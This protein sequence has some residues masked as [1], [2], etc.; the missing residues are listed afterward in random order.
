MTG[1]VFAT[2]S[3]YIEIGKIIHRVKGDVSSPNQIA[4]KPNR[5]L[6]RSEAKL[7]LEN[8]GLSVN[9]RNRKMLAHETQLTQ[10]TSSDEP[11]VDGRGTVKHY[12]QVQHGKIYWADLLQFANLVL[13]NVDIPQF[14]RLE[15][16]KTKLTY[17]PMSKPSQY[18]LEAEKRLES[19]VV[20]VTLKGKEKTNFYSHHDLAELFIRF[21]DVRVSDSK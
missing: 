21:G 13:M 1:L 3:K 14:W 2:F 8:R 16:K 4:P 7:E 20:H 15:Y 5:V 17:V 18:E 19:H 9:K 6:T 11:V 10:R 12:S